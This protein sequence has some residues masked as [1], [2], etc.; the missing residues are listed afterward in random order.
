M[1]LLYI[2]SPT[3]MRVA[4]KIVHTK[5]AQETESVCLS[6]F[7]P[8][9]VR[10]NKKAEKSKAAVALAAACA[11]VFRVSQDGSTFTPISKSDPNCWKHK[12]EMSDSDT[13]GK[14]YVWVSIGEYLPV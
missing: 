6:N 4:M 11:S 14:T 12:F 3:V 10:Y 1:V 8:G 5:A 13:L 2:L 7:R 9:S